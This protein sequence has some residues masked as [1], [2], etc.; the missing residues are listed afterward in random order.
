MVARTRKQERSSN[1]DW[2]LMY[3]LKYEEHVSF[4]SCRVTGIR[5][6]SL[7]GL[8]WNQWKEVKLWMK[9]LGGQPGDTP[10]S[11]YARVHHFLPRP[12]PCIVETPIPH[13]HHT[14]SHH[15]MATPKKHPG[16]SLSLPKQS[17]L[18]STLLCKTFPQWA[19]TF[20]LASTPPMGN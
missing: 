1:V 6:G 18:L 12:C 15:T 19:P 8:H 10:L 17:Q 3:H 9:R 7:V 5:N 16:P 13:P 14:A 4:N 20:S 2:E 11:S